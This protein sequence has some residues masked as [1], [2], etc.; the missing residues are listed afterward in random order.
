MGSTTIILKP[1][2]GKVL[3]LFQEKK[4]IRIPTKDSEKF[5]S[6]VDAVGLSYET[7]DDIETKLTR[8]TL[9]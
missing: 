5:K 4:Q 7:E 9:I 2:W 1:S 6:I 8:F 3:E